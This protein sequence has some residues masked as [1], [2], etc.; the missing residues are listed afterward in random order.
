MNE[1]GT[2]A[3][4][5]QEGIISEA[6][7]MS[8]SLSEDRV[9]EIIGKRIENGKT[10]WNKTYDLD[11]VRDK[12]EKRWLNKN[13]EVSEEELYDWE[14]EYPDNRIFLSVETL[15]S[16]VVSK[17]PVPEVVE[18]QDSDASRELASDFGKVLF[19]KAEDLHLKGALQ[20]VGRHLIM[21]YRLG[22]IKATW[23]FNGGRLNSNGNFSGD[24]DIHFVRPQKIILDEEAENPMDVPLIAENMHKTVEELGFL[25]PD[26]KDDLLS[27]AGR[28]EGKGVRMGTKLGYYETYFSF[29]NTKGLRQE[30]ICWK[31]NQ[32]LLDWGINPHFNY[33]DTPDKSNFFPS[34][35]KPYVLFNFLREG[36][37]ALDDTS[38]TEQAAGQQ[39][40]L[41]R[42]GRIVIGNAEK[43]ASTNV[44]N[45]M[46]VKA[47]DAQK[48]TGNPRDNILAKGD[49]RAAFTRVPPQ[50]V[51]RY[52]PE[53]MFDARNE[54]DNI[55]GTHAPLRGEKSASK[56]LGQDVM[57]QRSDLGRTATLTE[58][59]ET[60][61]T[62][63]YRHLAQLYKVFASA[64]HVIQYIGQDVGQTVFINFSQDKI[65]DGIQI[66]I[67]Q[68]SMSPDDKLT[69]RNEAVELA[70]I[71]GRI[72]PLTFAE[73]WHID[74]PRE[75][76]TRLFYFLFM[77]D[78][79]ASEVLQIGG[80]GGDQEAMSAIQ[81][82][83]A[84]ENVP[85][86]QNPTKEYVAYLNQFI[87]SPAF[88]QS[89]PEV[90]ALMVEHIRATVTNAKAGLGQ[91]DAQPAQSGGGIIDKVKGVFQNAQG[92]Q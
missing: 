56:T 17:I 52:I 26:K 60:G 90:Q 18:A 44:F 28:A 71:G 86:P 69:D 88:G 3:G 31:Y 13:L 11:T 70:K 32:V 77:P 24:A 67:N 1:S 54:I 72:D 85:P 8:L 68:G 12:N 92:Q 15:V 75:F 21:G 4:Q 16:N 82:L 2:L 45:T 53:M 61:A 74:R 55:Y 40:T 35:R 33:T 46:M 62:E 76:A 87:Q 25:F 80:S 64:E 6:D 50:Q 73:K 49:S 78:K 30:G 14:P 29:L 5:I 22:V 38:L 57:S 83:A 66:R 91:G 9:L 58:A 27:A 65:E 43:N 79:Y 34:P 23:D 47:S 63:V 36:R 7:A 41:E 48:Y 59:I 89:S 84:G 42:L 37:Y 81:R 39:D 20:M 51:P 10:F 19:R